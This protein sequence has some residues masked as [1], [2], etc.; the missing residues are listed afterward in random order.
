MRLPFFK[1]APRPQIPEGWRLYAIGDI[2][3]RMDLLE[4][5]LAQTEEDLANGPEA[6]VAYVFLGDYIDR[7]PASSEVIDLILALS[8]QRRVICLKGNHEAFLLEFFANPNR[9]LD[10]GRYGGLNTLMSYGLRPPLQPSFEQCQEIAAALYET[11]PAAHHEFLQKLHLSLTFGDFFFVHAGARPRIP[12]D[13]QSEE[14][15]LWIREDFLLHEAMFE[16]VIVHGHSPVLA[17]EVLPN[18]INIDTGAYA[19]GRLTCLV[20]EG[21]T[22]RFI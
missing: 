18:R 22:M 9:L 1:T 11:M 14:D 10:W 5:L 12:L 20:L 4:P 3:G 13:R 2:H 6:E 21:E 8:A 7:G 17:P 19:T 16:K 15:L